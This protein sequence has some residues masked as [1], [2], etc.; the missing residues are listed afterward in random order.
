MVKKVLSVMIAVL[1]LA[2]AL[3]GC[4]SS[5][6][7]TTTGAQTT[8]SGTEKKVLRVGMEC[9]YA[10]FNWTQTTTALS[11]G[12]TAIPIKGTS[13]YA[14]GYDVMLAKQLADNLGMDLE[15]VKVEWSSIIL[16]LQAGDYDAII[17]GM[18]YTEERD[19]TVDFTAPYYIRNNVLVI[20]KDGKFANATKL[21]DFAGASA[22]TQLG[23]TWEQYVPQIPEVKQQTYYETTAEVVMAVAMGSAD[24]GVLDEPTAKSAA[25][26]NPEVTYVKLDSTDGFA[27]P[28]GQSLKVCIAVKEGD[29]ELKDAL[30]GAL[31][32]IGWNE[33]KMTEYMDL[34]IELQP[35][36]E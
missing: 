17:A 3:V 35:L 16:G 22:T 8:G 15:I 29:A 2:T 30:D 36:S 31:T 14:Y 34:A 32:A 23:T 1:M 13:D 9:A 20:K 27:V 4:G 21:S 33:A 10:P 18:G 7:E 6:T 12:D 5:G 11:N 26:A 25:I 28:T 24:V 19:K